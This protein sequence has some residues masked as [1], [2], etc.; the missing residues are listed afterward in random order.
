MSSLIL[1]IFQS[2]RNGMS[3]VL[4]SEFGG[5]GLLLEL[6]LIECNLPELAILRQALKEDHQFVEGHGVVRSCD[7]C[8][9]DVHWSTLQLLQSLRDL[10]WPFCEPT[11]SATWAPMRLI[12]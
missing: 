3:Y 7:D 10:K 11:I 9:S 5:E 1:I 2:Q 4:V 6:H 12:Y 8:G